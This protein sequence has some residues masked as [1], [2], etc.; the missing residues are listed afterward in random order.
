MSELESFRDYCRTM[1]TARHKPDCSLPRPGYW[2]DIKPNPKCPGCNSEAD[3]A[4]FA[5]LA[6]EVDE[7]LTDDEPEGLFA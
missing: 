6:A 4:L 7:Y 3:R 2:L 1:S 5:R